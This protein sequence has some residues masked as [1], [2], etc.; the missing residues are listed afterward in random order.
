MIPEEVLVRLRCP[1]CGDE[2]R[3]DGSMLGCSS[4]HTLPIHDGYI[5][6]FSNATDADTR[7][8]LDSFG[9]EWTTFD[10]INPEDGQFWS[11]YFA[12]VPVDDLRNKVGLDAGC[13]KGRYAYFTAPYLKTL[14]ALDGSEAVRSAVRN[15][16]SFSNVTVLR[17]DVRDTPLADE[18][19]DFIYCLGVLHHLSEPREGFREL[20]RLLAPGGSFLLYV[21]SRPQTAGIRA[22]GLAAAGALRKATVGMRPRILRGLSAIIAVG[23]YVGFVVPGRLG[24]R[25]RSKKLSGLPLGTYRGRPIRSLWLDTF[26]RLSA[27]L[28]KRYVWEEI[29]PWFAEAGLQVMNRRENAGLFVLA[30]KPAE[31]QAKTA[32]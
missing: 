16:R 3:I 10:T 25:V 5:D 26:D 1:R 4:G 12:D 29:A 19:F 9:Y 15:L 13:G 22:A 2:V 7:R 31:E 30:R 27:P 6:A 28:E 23:L 18:S 32:V 20:L 17:A 11:N 24:D 8:T 21:Y 14:V